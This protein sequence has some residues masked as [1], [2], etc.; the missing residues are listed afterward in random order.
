MWYINDFN[1]E[2]IV[3]L[4]VSFDKQGASVTEIVGGH[5]SISV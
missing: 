3:N 4:Q 5:Y 1:Q 2:N